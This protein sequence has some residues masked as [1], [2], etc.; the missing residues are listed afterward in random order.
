V[1]GWTHLECI[2]GFPMGFALPDAFPV[3]DD[4][5]RSSHSIMGPNQLMGFALA[6]RFC[7]SEWFLH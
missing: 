7:I 2:L 6:N 5:G 4:P 1:A 3:L